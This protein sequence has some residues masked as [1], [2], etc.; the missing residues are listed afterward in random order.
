MN[1]KLLFKSFMKETQFDNFKIMLGGF[2]NLSLRKCSLKKTRILSY[3]N[4][5]CDSF[6]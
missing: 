4:V 6:L 3:E 2:C 5:F 1:P